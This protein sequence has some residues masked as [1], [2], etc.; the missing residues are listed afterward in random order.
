MLPLSPGIVETVLANVI[1]NGTSP[2][3]NPPRQIS[4]ARAGCPGRL[5][6]Q[7]TWIVP[8]SGTQCTSRIQENA[9]SPPRTVH[10]RVRG[11]WTPS[12]NTPMSTATATRQRT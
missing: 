12:R 9:G 6:A 1:S 8:I 11:P 3:P 7:Q 10:R 2:I 4:P 5:L